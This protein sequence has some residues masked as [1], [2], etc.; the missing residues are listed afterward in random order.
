MNCK[1]LAAAQFGP[2]LED[3]RST[4]ETASDKCSCADFFSQ[5][6]VCLAI[7]LVESEIG[8]KRPT[9]RKGKFQMKTVTLATAELTTIQK[10]RDL[11]R[12]LFLQELSSEVEEEQVR[13]HLKILL[14]RLCRMVSQRFPDLSK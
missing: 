1:R 5:R 11:I 12:A 4:L 13:S 9:H 2:L 3:F 8:A 6:L 14:D 10:A 7:E